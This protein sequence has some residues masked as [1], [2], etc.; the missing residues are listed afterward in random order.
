MAS[1]G[2]RLARLFGTADQQKIVQQFFDSEVKNLEGATRIV[3]RNAARILKREIQ[4]QLKKNFKRGAHP[5]PQL[6]GTFFR[7]VKIYDLDT[8]LDRG[9][10]P[11]SIVRMGVPWISIF[12][13][14]GTVSGKPNLAILLPDGARFGFKRITK[15]NPWKKVWQDW[16]KHL[17]L[18]RTRDG[19]VV[20]YK[21]PRLDKNYAVYKFQR[22][23]ELPK[24]L[25]FYALAEAVGD[26]VPEQILKLMEGSYD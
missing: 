12:E 13:E 18:V 26:Q 22:R 1:S 20:V 5:V 23:V 16:G 14:G 11:A 9:L 19:T 21:H 17:F 25:S 24:K 3:S 2:R 8:N 6:K 4:K 10:G 15:G 7:A